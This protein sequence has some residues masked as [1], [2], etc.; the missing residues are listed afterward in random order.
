[1]DGQETI[2]YAIDLVQLRFNRRIHNNIDMQRHDAGYDAMD[3]EVTSSFWSHNLW[4]V[5]MTTRYIPGTYYEVTFD[6][7]LGVTKVSSYRLDDEYLIDH[8]VV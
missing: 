1:M 4:R 6:R 2:E 8:K 3:M 7:K 5:C